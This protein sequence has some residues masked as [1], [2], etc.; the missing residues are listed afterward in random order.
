MMMMMLS[1]HT[2]MMIKQHRTMIHC[3]TA[4]TH[5]EQLT[6]KLACRRA[7]HEF[8]GKQ[9]DSQQ[10]RPEGASVEPR[11]VH[12]VPSPTLQEVLIHTS[13]EE[14]TRACSLPAPTSNSRRF[15]GGRQRDQEVNRPGEVS[16]SEGSVRQ[17]RDESVRGKAAAHLMQQQ[18]QL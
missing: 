5:N 7:H 13:D 14:R 2:I 18:Q 11:H 8:P 6:N 1:V 9:L 10:Q 15:S 16:E 12:A 3:N 4:S 17:H